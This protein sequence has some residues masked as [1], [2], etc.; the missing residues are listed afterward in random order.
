MT[1]QWLGWPQALY[2]LREEGTDTFSGACVARHLGNLPVAASRARSIEQK[3]KR[4]ANFALKWEREN[5]GGLHWLAT[6]A[7][8]ALLKEH[9]ASGNAG[10]LGLRLLQVQVIARNSNS[11]AIQCQ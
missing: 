3:K 4:W 7:E 6:P 11:Q 9:G 2:V 10:S 8:I 5:G 1:F